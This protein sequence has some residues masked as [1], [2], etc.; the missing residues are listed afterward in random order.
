M[1]DEHMLARAS[2]LYD[3]D[4]DTVQLIR[5]WDGSPNHIYSFEKNEQGYIL[6]AS[7]GSE[8]WAN[9]TQAEMDWLDY[10]AK[11]GARVSLPLPSMYGRIVERAELDGEDWVICAFD[12]AEGRHAQRDDPDTWNEQVF[13]DWGATMGQIHHLT[14]HYHPSSE[15]RTRPTFDGCEALQP[16]LHHVPELEKTVHDHV[17]HLLSLP[18]TQGSFGLIHQDFHQLNF[19]VDRGKVHVFD[20]DDSV[21]GYFA[22]D[23]GI[24]L[25]HALLWGLPEEIDR[26]QA[27]SQAILGGFMKG[28]LSQNALDDSCRSTIP[29]FMRFRQ[30]CELAWALNDPATLDAQQAEIERVQQGVLFDGVHVDASTFI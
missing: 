15:A 30:M 5:I 4:P 7:K 9:R 17:A 28:Y 10:L 16:G 23:I 3:F 13:Q 20:F 12:K 11:R 27:A 19:F 21:Y 26:R 2:E 6:R 25:Y 18:R 14:K 29:D 8:D 1:A 24:A 22:L